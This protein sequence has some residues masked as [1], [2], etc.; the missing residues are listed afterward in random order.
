MHINL[1]E[2]RTIRLAL[3][4]FAHQ[5]CPPLERQQVLVRTDNVTAKAYV[6]NQGDLPSTAL[7]KVAAAIITWAEDHLVAIWVEHMAGVDNAAADWLSRRWIMEIEWQ[8]NPRVFSLVR[9]RFGTPLA[10]LFA[11]RENAQIQRFSHGSHKRG[12]RP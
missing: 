11:T 6:K 7:H 1:L 10:D 3:G 8:L 5:I 12:Q 9:E 2:L 4:K